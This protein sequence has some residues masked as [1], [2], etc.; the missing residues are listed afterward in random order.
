MITSN[1]NNLELTEFTG[2]LDRSQHCRAAFPVNGAVG[3]K[4]SATVYFEIEPG[5][6][7]GR[8]TDSAE[9]LLLVLDGKAEAIVGNESGII[10]KG[11]IAVVPKMI[12]HDVK[13]TGSTKL[14]MLGFFGGA[15]HIIATF[16]DKWMPVDSNVVDTLQMV[17]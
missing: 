4:D 3:T 5:E 16:D 11:E 15:N 17:Q 10:S 12:P 1:L 8:H 7:L 14:R 9:E 2:K 6:H 13:N